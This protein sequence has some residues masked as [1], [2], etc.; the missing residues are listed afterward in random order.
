MVSWLR[1]FCTHAPR[2]HLKLSATSCTTTGPG[3]RPA[4]AELWKASYN[5]IT[6]PD[7][8]EKVSSSTDSLRQ[9]QTGRCD[10]ANLNGAVLS[11]S[12][13]SA[14][15]AM[16]RFTHLKRS[17]RSAEVNVFKTCK[18]SWRRS[19]VRRRAKLLPAFLFT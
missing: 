2:R 19:S 12:G 10:V 18:C 1:G 17:S 6:T 13:R 16:S 4:A 8:S 14:L 3:S 9:F 5:R 11:V 15:N 7:R